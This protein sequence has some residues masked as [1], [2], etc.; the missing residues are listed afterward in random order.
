MQGKCHR[1]MGPLRESKQRRAGPAGDDTVA[2]KN[3]GPFAAI[4]QPQ[5]WCRRSRFGVGE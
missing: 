5:A 1:D 4:D 2:A 3:D